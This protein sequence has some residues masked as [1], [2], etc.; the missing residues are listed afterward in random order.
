LWR[1]QKR[2]ARRVGAIEASLEGSP[3]STLTA[4]DV[5]EMSLTEMHIVLRRLAVER[6]LLDAVE[7]LI[8]RRLISV[9]SSH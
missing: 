6:D 1:Q 9:R 4:D 7:R 3:P 2:L 5:A 8:R